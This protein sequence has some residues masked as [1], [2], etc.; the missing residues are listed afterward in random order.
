MALRV[1]DRLKCFS[2]VEL[3]RNVEANVI[4]IIHF[5]KKAAWIGSV[6]ETEI[7][8]SWNRFLVSEGYVFHYGTRYRLSS[9]FYNKCKRGVTNALLHMGASHIAQESK[10]DL[11]NY[12]YNMSKRAMRLPLKEII[13]HAEIEIV[14][15]FQFRSTAFHGGINM[16]QPRPYVSSNILTRLDESIIFTGDMTLMPLQPLG[17]H[18]RPRQ[19]F[20]SG[21]SNGAVIVMPSQDGSTSQL[22]ESQNLDAVVE[23]PVL[24]AEERGPTT[25]PSS[26]TVAIEELETTVPIEELETEEFVREEEIMGDLDTC[27][28][29]LD[30]LVAVNDGTALRCMPCMHVFHEDCIMTWLED[31]NSC[32]LCRFTL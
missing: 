31:S 2:S 12:V 4:L 24:L 20:Q 10:S 9:G 27:S 14:T 5:R 25:V 7:S 1:I 3:Q 17:M 23:E 28:I 29:C 21:T 6:D 30:S 26:T 22:D 8:H 32:P 16:M 18:H 15:I 11:L 19:S 13:I